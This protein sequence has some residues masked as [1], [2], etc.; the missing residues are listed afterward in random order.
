MIEP[1]ATDVNRSG[2]F[3]LID[4]AIDAWYYG[5]KAVDTDK[6]KYDANHDGNGTIDDVD[7]SQ[8]VKKFLIT[9]IILQIN[10]LTY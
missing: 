10:K 5:D 8:I 1:A 4:F 6:T 7:L 9:Q 2:E 3:T